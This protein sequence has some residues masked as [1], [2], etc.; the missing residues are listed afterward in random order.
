MLKRVEGRGRSSRA[1]REPE[2]VPTMGEGTPKGR[3]REKRK[4]L[5]ERAM[6]RKLTELSHRTR[7]APMLARETR[8]VEGDLTGRKPTSP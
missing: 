3:K 5:S 1:K 6:L 7:A 8:E 2:G 4:K